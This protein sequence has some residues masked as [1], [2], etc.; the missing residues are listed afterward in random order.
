[1]LIAV[2]WTQLVLNRTNFLKKKEFTREIDGYE[3]TIT[4]KYRYSLTGKVVGKD[5]Y[6]MDAIDK[7]SPMDLSI[8]WGKTIDPE[9]SQYIKYSKTPRH[10]NYRYY[11]PDGVKTL[12][13]RYISEHGSNNHLI[14]ADEATYDLAKEVRVGDIVTIEGYLV[15]T[16][17][18]RSDGAYHEWVSSTSRSDSGENACEL[19]YVEKIVVLDS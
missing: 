15:D 17:G 8:A 16:Y 9:Y 2:F 5:K 18:K 12:S 6:W 1:M 19:I 10:C 11:F 14:F 3:F 4:A 7:L 13:N